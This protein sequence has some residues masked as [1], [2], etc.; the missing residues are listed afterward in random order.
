MVVIKLAIP[1]KLTKLFLSHVKAIVPVNG[2]GS[3]EFTK[4]ITSVRLF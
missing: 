3:K 4:N 2:I 1:L